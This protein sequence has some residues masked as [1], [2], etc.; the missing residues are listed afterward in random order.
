MIRI[1]TINLAGDDILKHVDVSLPPSSIVLAD[2]GGIYHFRFRYKTF[3]RCNPVYHLSLFQA[4]FAQRLP[5]I[6]LKGI[7]A[8]VRMLKKLPSGRL[9]KITLVRLVPR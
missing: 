6:S 3:Y 7:Q 5:G 8:E 2:A 9:L 1:N 4:M